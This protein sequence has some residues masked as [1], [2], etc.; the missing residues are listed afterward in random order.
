MGICFFGGILVY[1]M[2]DL[3]NEV[4]IAYANKRGQKEH[5]KTAMNIAKELLMN[6]NVL[7]VQMCSRMVTETPLQLTWKL[8]PKGEHL[9]AIKYKEIAIEFAS[10]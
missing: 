3:V 8:G 10:L 1:K 9:A 7:N 5:I 4:K 2:E 6:G